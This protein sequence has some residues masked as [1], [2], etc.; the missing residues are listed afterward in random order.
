MRRHWD[1]MVALVKRML[2]LH[3][4]QPQM[5]QAKTILK[6]QTEATDREIDS[7][8]YRLYDLTEDEIKVVQGG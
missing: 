8:V 1:Q 3:Q 4:Q 2:D 7:L 6:R 5:P